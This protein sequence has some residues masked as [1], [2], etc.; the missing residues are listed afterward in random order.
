M[1]TREQQAAQLMRRS[2][3][4]DHQTLNSSWFATSGLYQEE[5][6]ETEDA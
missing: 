1:T 2:W 5:F 6:E 4:F 3:A